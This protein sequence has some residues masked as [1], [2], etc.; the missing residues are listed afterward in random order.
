M[1]NIATSQLDAGDQQPALRA[2]AL[3]R[4]ARRRNFLAHVVVH[5]VG[6]LLLAAVWAITEYHNAG[7]WPTGLRS[8]RMNHDWDPWIVYPLLAGSVALALHAWVAFGRRPASER[9]ISREIE[10]LRPERVQVR[11]GEV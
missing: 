1:S 11:G 6:S 3:E 4:F 5:L 9:E 7:G 10:R 8:G 2:E